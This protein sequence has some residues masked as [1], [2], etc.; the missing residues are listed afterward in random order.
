ML[1]K[2]IYQFID[3]L[4]IVRSYSNHTAKGYLLD[5]K[6]FCLFLEKHLSISLSPIHL[7]E[8][9]VIEQDLDISKIDKRVIRFYLDDLKKREL[10]KR[11][12][13]RRIASIK[14]YYK[15]LMLYKLIEE[16]PIEDLESVKLDKSLPMTLDIKQVEYLM[17][18]PKED[19]LGLRDRAMMELLYSSALRISELANLRVEDLDLNQKTLKLRG[20]GKKERIVPFTQMAKDCL[21]RY[22]EKREDKERL[23]FL[24][25]FNK[26]ITTRSIERAFEKYLKLAGLPGGI[27]PHTIRHS[28]A[29]HWLENGMD[30]K[31]IQLLLG[32]SNLSTTSIY[33]HVSSKLKQKVYQKAHPRA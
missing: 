16:N 23:I 2:T 7:K 11:T 15:Y 21:K 6:D 17:S 18:L 24:N 14:S 20:K 32:H 33:T 26:P 13:A 3:H 4:L 30:L 9:S 10:K 27:S 12:L 22:L 8:R 29:T 19:V 31:T 5:L 25:R 1:L 28:I